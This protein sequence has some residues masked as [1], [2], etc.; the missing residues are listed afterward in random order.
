M[1]KVLEVLLCFHLVMWSIW[2]Y[3]FQFY[4]T[5]LKHCSIALCKFC[6]LYHFLSNCATLVDTC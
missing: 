1:Y 5:N 4:L 6:K 3:H 2:L